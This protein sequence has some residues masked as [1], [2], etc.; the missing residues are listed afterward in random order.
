MIEDNVLITVRNRNA[1]STRYTLDDG[2]SRFFEYNEIKKVPFGELKTLSYSHGGQGILRDCLIIE[3]KDALAYLNMEVEPEY[4]YSEKEVKEILLNGSLD[5]LEDTLNFA[6]EGVIEMIK[7]LAVELEIPDT[8]K[9][10]MIYKKTGM[11]INNAIYINKVMAE[12]SSNEGSEEGPKRKTTPLTVEKTERKTSVPATA[13]K[14]KVV[15]R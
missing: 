3:D 6:P 10:E 8:R 11:N 9:R 12:E 15:K 7:K 5:Q 13:D 4:Y 1:G 14:Y 2:T